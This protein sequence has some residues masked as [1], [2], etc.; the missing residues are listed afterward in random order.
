M[1]RL[2]L[3]FRGTNRHVSKVLHLFL[4]VNV[5]RNIFTAIADECQ[6]TGRV[7]GEGGLWRAICARSCRSLLLR[8][9][10]ISEDSS[11]LS[12]K[13]KTLEKRVEKLGTGGD[14]PQVRRLVESKPAHRPHL[15]LSRTGQK[16][17]DF[18]VAA[19]VRGL[20]GERGNRPRN[21]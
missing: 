14:C 5:Q 12:S 18:A 16:I 17:I 13:E 2:P 7:I 6:I 1:D 21:G 4:S 8:F 10:L 19:A 20:R 3:V 9:A 15:W 11:F